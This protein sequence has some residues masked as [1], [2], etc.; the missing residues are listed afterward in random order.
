MKKLLIIAG[1][2]VHRKVVSAARESG[3][4]TIVADCLAPEK[5]PAKMLANEYWDIDIKDVDTI[6]SKCVVPGIGKS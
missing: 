4:Y 1:V 6:V 5:S 2:D 3:V